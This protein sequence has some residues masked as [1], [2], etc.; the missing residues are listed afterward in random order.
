MAPALLLT[1]ALIFLLI[2]VVSF[3]HATVVDDPQDKA[4]E[5]ARGLLF[6]ILAVGAHMFSTLALYHPM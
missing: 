6:L 5:R 4:W 2:S 1:F 3:V